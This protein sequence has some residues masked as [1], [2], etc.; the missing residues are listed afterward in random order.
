MRILFV[1]LKKN[2]VVM[3]AQRFPKEAKARSSY[4]YGCND[5]GQPSVQ[6]KWGIPFCI[7]N[8]LGTLPLLIPITP[9]NV[10]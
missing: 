7:E 1:P 2:T 8:G 3:T 6:V 10:S 5:M 9:K 4:Y